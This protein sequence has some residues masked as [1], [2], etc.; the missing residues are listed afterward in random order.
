MPVFSMDRH[1]KFGP[2]Q[3]VHQLQLFLAGVTGH[4]N[5]GIIVIHVDAPLIQ[6]VDDP[7]H[8]QL[9]SRDRMGGQHHQVLGGQL[10]LTVVGKGHPV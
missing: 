3:I 2:Y 6:F 5:L 7:P 10:D 9:V 8:Q 1:E 4:M